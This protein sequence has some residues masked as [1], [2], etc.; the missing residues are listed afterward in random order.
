MT[1]W[2]SSAA[3]DSMI[4][5]A[6]YRYPLET[7]GVLAGYFSDCGQAVICHSIG[8]GPQAK[9]KRHRFAP[10][11]EWQ[12]KH[13]DELYARSNGNLVYVGDWHTHPNS[14][15][16]MSLLDRRT[17]SAIAAHPDARLKEPLMLIGGGHPQSWDWLCHQY[18]GRNS[19]GLFATTRE[20]DI[21]I[22]PL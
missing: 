15:G 21:Q 8:P 10:D 3:L 5:E 20:L 12:C 17:L 9:H 16:K 14:V 22:F 13:I 19:F 11:H 1:V 2:L 7:G 6:N 4:R 18:S